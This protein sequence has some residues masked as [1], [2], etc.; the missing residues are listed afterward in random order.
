MA[1]NENQF[2]L[3]KPEQKIMWLIQTANDQGHLNLG[4][5]IGIGSRR[6]FDD[7]PK[8]M[9]EEYT[10]IEHKKRVKRRQDLEAKGIHTNIG[11]V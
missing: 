9:F 10:E 11:G 5:L 1:G 7:P 8:N 3:K 2:G 6:S 4:D